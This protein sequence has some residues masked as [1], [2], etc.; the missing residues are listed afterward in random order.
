MDPIKV[1]CYGDSNTYGYDPKTG[2]RH[3]RELRWTG[4]LQKKLGGDYQV[5]EEGCNGRSTVYPEPGNEWKSGLYGLKSC[6]NTYK[7]IE[8]MVIMLGTNDL[9]T[10]YGVTADEIAAGAE[11]VASDSE[12]FLLEKSG[13]KPVTVLVSPIYLKDGIVDSPF[14]DRYDEV[15]V[16]ISKRLAPL[17][18][19][20]AKRHGWIFLDAAKYAEASD[21]DCL[22]MDPEN[23]ALLAEAMYRAVCEA[24]ERLDQPSKG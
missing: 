17:Y 16:Q 23:H 21:D 19:E 20:I 12:D 4:I 22:H 8:I 14:G 5:V 7:P 24:I 13:V 15:S 9:K 18:E 11:R 1:F 2:L 10:V 3:P 6:L